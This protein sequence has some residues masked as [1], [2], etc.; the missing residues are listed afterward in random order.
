MNLMIKV[1]FFERIRVIDVPNNYTI[2]TIHL[3]IHK[4]NSTE[5]TVAHYTARE[6]PFSPRSEPWTVDAAHSREAVEWFAV[7][8]AL[9]L[10]P[11]QI[12]RRQLYV[13]LCT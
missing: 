2:V 13:W 5:A 1:I 3:A 12:P 7:A 10:P 8:A 11:F 6:H 4:R 9:S